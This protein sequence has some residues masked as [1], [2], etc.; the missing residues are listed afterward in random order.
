MIIAKFSQKLHNLLENSRLGTILLNVKVE[1]VT[2]IY[3]Q[4][5]A[6]NHQQMFNVLESKKEGEFDVIKETRRA[7][8][9]CGK[10]PSRYRPSAEA[11]LRRLRTKKELYQINNVVDTINLISIN[12]QY[13]IGGF[14]YTKI[15][16]EMICDI[17][18][19]DEYQ[20]IGRG[21]LN[22]EHMPGLKDSSGFFGTPTSDSVRTMVTDNTTELLL[23][24]YDFFGNE[25]LNKAM[26][27]GEQM[28]IEHCSGATLSKSI[29]ES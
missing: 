3:N 1:P 4:F 11:L 17:G 22:I 23:V 18:T 21:I 27:Y 29:I 19:S 20:A 8:K 10:E 7:Y 14:D 16:G 26:D 13:S 9:L 15:N 2:V 25:S 6:K 12:T 24:F 5:L 28:F